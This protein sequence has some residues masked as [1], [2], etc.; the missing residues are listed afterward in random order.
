MVITQQSHRDFFLRGRGSLPV[1]LL[2]ESLGDGP[3]RFLREAELCLVGC[4]VVKA[5]GDV[6]NVVCAVTVVAT[7]VAVGGVADG[8]I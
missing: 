7:A 6:R 1:I 3:E 4:K 5:G 8:A 2:G